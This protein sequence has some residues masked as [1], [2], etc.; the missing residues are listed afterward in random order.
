MYIMTRL[1]EVHP[2]NN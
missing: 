2:H 1:L